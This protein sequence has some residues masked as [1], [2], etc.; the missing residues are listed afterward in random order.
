[1]SRI[2]RNQVHVWDRLYALYSMKMYWAQISFRCSVSVFSYHRRSESPARIIQPVPKP[3]F[4]WSDHRVIHER[5]MSRINR[6]QVH[7]W[8]RLYALYSMKMYWAQIPF[9]CSVSAFSNRRNILFSTYKLSSAN[10]C[11]QCVFMEIS[12]LKTFTYLFLKYNMEVGW[13]GG[14]AYGHSKGLW[15]LFTSQMHALVHSFMH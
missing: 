6:N 4:F 11:I 5:S 12:H 10:T 8:D 9:R 7:V 15:Q 3:H 14:L 1:M 13:I 2:N